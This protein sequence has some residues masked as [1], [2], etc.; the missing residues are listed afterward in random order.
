M[1]ET[2]IFFIVFGALLLVFCKPL[3]LWGKE[4]RAE[5]RKVI[6]LWP[7]DVTNIRMTAAGGIVMI[8]MGIGLLLSA[9]AFR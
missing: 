9:T 2:S 1:I 5:L 4:R 7:D 3:G 6:P 8:L